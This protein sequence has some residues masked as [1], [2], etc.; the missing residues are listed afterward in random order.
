[1]KLEVLESDS[2]I[3]R[4]VFDAANP[5]E[6]SFGEC[7]DIAEFVRLHER[8]RLIGEDGRTLVEWPER[9]EVRR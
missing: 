2:W 4:R 7:A 3:Q 8:V 9:Q 1:V 5:S 6:L